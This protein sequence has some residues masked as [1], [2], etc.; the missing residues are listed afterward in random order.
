MPHL[1]YLLNHYDML[2]MNVLWEQRTAALVVP[3]ADDAFITGG[4]TAVAGHPESGIAPWWLA[5]RHP[6]GRPG[7][8]ALQ[9]AAELLRKKGLARGRIGIEKK[10]M[11]VAVYDFLRSELPDAE[12]VSA[13]LL[14]PQIRFIKTARE[15]RLLKT[16][17]GIG[18]RAMEAY[19]QALRSGASVREAQRLRAQRA[20]DYGG[21]WVGGA[22]GVA[23][24]GG[25]DET[26]AWWDAEARSRFY[27]TEARRWRAL[28]DE[29]PFFVTHFETTFQ[30]YFSD[31]AWHEFYG[32]EPD[33]GQVLHWGDRQVTSRE[34]RRDF[35]I[36][37][38]VQSEALQQITPG[39][40]HLDA[41]KALDSYLAAD[42]EAGDHISH[43]YVHGVGLEIHE[44][45][46]LTGYIPESTPADGPIYFQPG[47]VVSSEWFTR[48]W[49]VEE[50]F[51]MTESGWEPLVELKG[52]TDPAA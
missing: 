34:A 6:G 30:S 3:R 22:Y 2:H 35:E 19:M 23:W 42:P 9:K 41:R 14:I 13:D 7:R 39:M 50:P 32:P 27:S 29:T 48:L 40:S 36:L 33:G 21:E 52:L 44:E 5:E 25:N 18:L 20:L 38:R 10:W 31:M 26:P 46:V 43:Y 1:A 16:A 28:P 37:R 49:T 15:Q 47:A 17:A 8:D 11:P 24:T 4:H 12:L 45:P 51:V